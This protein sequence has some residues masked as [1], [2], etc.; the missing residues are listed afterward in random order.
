M[1]SHPIFSDLCDPQATGD[2]VI[3]S[4]RMSRMVGGLLVKDF[5]GCTSFS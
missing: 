3:A 4:M 5:Q 2:E 1:V